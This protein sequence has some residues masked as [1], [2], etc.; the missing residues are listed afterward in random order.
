[1]SYGCHNRPSLAPTAWVQVGWAKAPNVVV[2]GNVRLQVVMRAPIPDPMTKDCQ[3]TLS[4]LG[5][6][7]PGCT[8]C[9]RR[10]ERVYALT[11]GR[12]TPDFHA[13]LQW[14]SSDRQHS[15]TIIE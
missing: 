2:K 13:A 9:N 5:R 7:D 14:A 6:T 8:G 10:A 4:D 3:Y 15:F 12:R 1:M 11:D